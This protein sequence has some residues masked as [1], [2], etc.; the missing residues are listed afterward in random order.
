[1]QD[2]PAWIGKMQTELQD[3]PE[4]RP[5]E[6]EFADPY[7]YI[8]SISVEGAKFVPCPLFQLWLPA[9]SALPACVCV[10]PADTERAG[11]AWRGQNHS[12][13]ELPPQLPAKQGQNLNYP[14]TIVK[15]GVRRRWVVRGPSRHA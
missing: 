8:R 9:F 14:P 2:R 3:V 1:V 12:A 11:Q 13:G 7:A 5:T 10:V 6:E 4:F 15:P